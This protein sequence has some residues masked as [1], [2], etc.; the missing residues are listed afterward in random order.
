MA[1]ILSRPQCVKRHNLNGVFSSKWISLS[2]TM[3]RV[4]QPCIF[5]RALSHLTMYSWCSQVSK[6]S[7]SL[8]WNMYCMC[9][10]MRT[11]TV[12]TKGCIMTSWWPYFQVMCSI[13]MGPMESRRSSRKLLVVQWSL[14]FLI[15]NLL[16]PDY[17]CNANECAI[18]KC[19]LQ[20]YH[21]TATS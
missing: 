4:T 18:C 12:M 17:L 15:L 16:I 11:W 3:Y 1:A 10:W 14:G 6:C 5:L 20:P 19:S 9:F 21:I 8:N 7:T 2:K 13:S